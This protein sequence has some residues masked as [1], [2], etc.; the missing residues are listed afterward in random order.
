MSEKYIYEL[1]DKL[2]WDKVWKALPDCTNKSFE[3]IE[4]DSR[5]GYLQVMMSVDGD[6]WV[7][8]Y[9][10]RMMSS[11]RFRTDFGGGGRSPRVRQALFILMMAIDAENEDKPQ[12]RGE[13]PKGD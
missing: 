4:D 2:D 1:L 6:V 7:K 12:E 13:P 9:G 11:C 8:T 3:R 10:S 5:D